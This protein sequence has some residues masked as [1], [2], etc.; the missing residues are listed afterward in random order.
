MHVIDISCRA[1]HRYYCAITGSPQ[2]AAVALKAWQELH[3]DCTEYLHSD[4]TG[5][6]SQP[7]REIK[8]AT[9][10]DGVVNDWLKLEKAQGQR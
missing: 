2:L 4:Y 9:Y 6:A 7:K 10:Y 3:S 8:P 1:G 5:Q